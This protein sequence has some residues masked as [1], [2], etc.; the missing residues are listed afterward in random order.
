MA[1]NESSSPASPSASPADRHAGVGRRPRRRVD[2][3]R[4]RAPP[5][6]RPGARHGGGARPRAASAASPSSPRSFAPRS[7]RRGRARPRARAAARRTGSTRRSSRARRR[8]HRR[9]SAPSPRTPPSSDDAVQLVVAASRLCDGA[10]VLARRR[11]VQLRGDQGPRR[12]P[13][14]AP[15]WTAA[16]A[17][18]RAARYYARRTYPQ[19][20]RA[21]ETGSGCVGRRICVGFGEER[22][23]SSRSSEA[24][25]RGRRRPRRRDG[26]TSAASPRPISRRTRRS[27][28]PSSRPSSS[29]I[30]PVS[31][32]TVVRE[33]QAAGD[34]YHV[35]AISGGN[36]ALLATLLA[37]HSVAVVSAV[38]PRD[39][40]P[41][42]T[43]IV[44]ALRPATRRQQRVGRPRR[45]RGLALSHDVARRTTAGRN[46]GPRTHR[47]CSGDRRS[48]GDGRRRRMALLRRLAQH[49][50][51]GRPVHAMG[52][53]ARRRVT[54]RAKSHARILD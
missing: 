30:A 39:R 18:A 49:R 29:A 13:P 7:V 36:V 46:R 52:A 15:A 6:G 4:R 1:R 48:A 27:R 31:M 24:P 12:R 37:A 25:R 35:I 54:G 11:C 34:G 53:G 16:A 50:H 3:P 41:V 5:R 51:R 38:V 26:V 47:A 20:G 23:A 44:I 40:R 10:G 21:G 9:S 17:P 32:T 33:L 8:A 14:P 2:R 19:P 43:A 42:T 45:A 28:P 22:G